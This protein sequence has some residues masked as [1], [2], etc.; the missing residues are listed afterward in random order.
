MLIAEGLV[1]EGLEIVA[2]TRRRYDGYKRNPWN[3]LELGNHYARSL[4]SWAVCDA[5]CGTEIDVPGD[6]ISFDPKLNA[7]DFQCFF[8]AGGAWGVYRQISDPVTGETTSDIEVLYG[9]L[10]LSLSSESKVDGA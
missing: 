8:V 7:K 2:A 3:E 10:A 9:T 5:L 1:D 6:H 4:A